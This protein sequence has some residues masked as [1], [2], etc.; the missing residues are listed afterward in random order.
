MGATKYKE[1]AQTFDLGT[2]DPK[3]I[4]H[5][6][7]K[8]QTLFSQTK[9][10]NVLSLPSCNSPVFLL[11]KSQRLGYV[12]KE[13]WDSNLSISASPRAFRLQP[14][15]SHFFQKCKATS[16]VS[17]WRKR[18]FSGSKTNHVYLEAETRIGLYSRECSKINTYKQTEVSDLRDKI[19]DRK[20]E[21]EV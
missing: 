3:K 8:L 7:I 12:A 20:G 6:H 9:T 15:H 1:I 11:Q 16:S 21:C 5:I 14:E 2:E 10:C 19:T 4:S 13:T 17:C 18:V